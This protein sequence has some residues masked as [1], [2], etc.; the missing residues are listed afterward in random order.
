[1]MFK[2]SELFFAKW[3]LNWTCTDT[4]PSTDNNSFY[5]C[6]TV[7]VNA[8]CPP[9]QFITSGSLKYGRWDNSVCPGLGVNSSTPITYQ[10]FNLP[11]YCLTGVSSCVIANFNLVFGD[12][13]PGVA[14][15]VSTN[16]CKK[17]I[18]IYKLTFYI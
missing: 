7:P 8:I 16:I 3:M 18:Y 17:N 14:K 5:A 1:M 2:E 10:V 15:H 9:G 11:F 13:F 4:R 12:P 6:D